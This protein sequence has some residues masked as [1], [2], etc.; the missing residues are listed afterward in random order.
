[1]EKSEIQLS[2]EYN[3]RKIS[4]GNTGE[5]YQVSD[6]E[7]GEEYYFKPAISKSGESRSYRAYIQEA[8]YNI[9]Q[10]INPENVVKCNSIEVNGIFGAIQEKIPVDIASTI[11]FIE[12]F[13]NGIG[14]LQPEIISQIINEYLV[15]YILFLLIYL[16]N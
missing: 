11:K 13:D 4:I 12:Y 14:E 10:I 8:A 6:K 9:Q 16:Q 1:M 5:M 7:N 2:S 15:D 3:A